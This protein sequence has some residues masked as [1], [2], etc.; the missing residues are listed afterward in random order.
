ML[1]EIGHFLQKIIHDQDLKS[2]QYLDYYIKI[3]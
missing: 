2:L 3:F 1:K